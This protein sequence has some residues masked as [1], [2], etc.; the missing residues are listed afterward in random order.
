MIGGGES[1]SAAV[2]A[3]KTA[4]ALLVLE[5]GKPVGVLTRQ[6]LLGHVNS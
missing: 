3:L 4:T 5:G 6:D 1:I 2:S